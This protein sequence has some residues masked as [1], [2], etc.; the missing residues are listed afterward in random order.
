MTTPV[1]FD[2]RGNVVGGHRTVE[3]VALSPMK[4]EVQPHEIARSAG[5]LVP[6]VGFGEMTDALFVRQM[7][8]ALYASYALN[9]AVARDFLEIVRVAVCACTYSLFR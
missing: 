9:E 8:F 5:S 3:P 7:A 2:E 1:D 6:C 4:D